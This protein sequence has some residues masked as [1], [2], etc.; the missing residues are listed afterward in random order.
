MVSGINERRGEN[1]NEDSTVVYEC[2]GRWEGICGL[3]EDGETTGDSEEWHR[4]EIMKSD[5]FF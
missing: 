2:E 1:A 5:Q 4:E 3:G